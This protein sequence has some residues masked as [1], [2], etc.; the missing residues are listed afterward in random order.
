MKGFFLPDE[1]ENCI[2]AERIVKK[3]QV[4]D[5]NFS[6]IFEDY[7]DNENFQLYKLLYGKED[8]TKFEY[9]ELIKERRQVIKEYICKCE[10]KK[11]KKLIDVCNE[12]KKID[13]KKLWNIGIGLGIVFDEISQNKDL[14]VA[15]IKYYIKND[16]PSNLNPIHILDILFSLMSD[17][18]VFQII[19]TDAYKQKND[20]LYAYYHELPKDS[21]SKDHLKGLYNFLNGTTDSD[22]IL[23][24]I[25][26]VDFLDK[27]NSID[28][29]VF[30]KGCK[31]ILDKIEDSLNFGKVYFILLF[32]TNRYTPKELISKF[33]NNLE[34]LEKIY[35]AMLSCDENHDNNGQFLRE[36]YLNSPSIL[37]K[38]IEFM[39][40]KS[41]DFFT[42]NKER[43]YCFFDLDNFVEIY[44]KIFE[45]LIIK[46]KFP[47]INVP[48]FFENLF[49]LNSNEQDLF[50]K[51]DKW[52]IQCI[53]L[54]HNDEL[55]MYCLFSA[56]SRL[57][58]D[59]MKKYF[60]LFLKYNSK[61]EYFIKLPLR[62]TSYIITG[63]T[64]PMYY[65]WIEFHESLLPELVGLKWLK[66]KQYV[67]KGIICLKKLIES[68]QIDEIL[69]G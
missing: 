56:I 41:K 33:K 36:I 51:Q 66:H 13:T 15:T 57:E 21:I 2:I 50:E 23:T 44:N 58:V 3:I 16:T 18:E 9:E 4:V 45:Q 64:I 65:K 14:Y 49:L 52:I 31:I 28:S 67:E 60:L 22:I 34:L 46:C 17:S 48:D 37:D 43:N 40:E 20:W 6:K 26:D 8:I 27:Y 42:T 12:V 11:L 54:F 38:Y 61:I 7:F 35:C 55:K 24:S 32:K 5:A 47:T 19:N 10:L 1:L 63:S 69:E 62:P 39:V 29:Q 68:E 59:R 53:Q 25:R 30:M